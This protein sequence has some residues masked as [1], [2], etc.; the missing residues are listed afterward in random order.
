MFSNFF[1]RFVR[2]G[3]H[4]MVSVTNEGFLGRT[5][6]P[7]Q[8]LAMNVFRAVEN[9]VAIVRAATTGVSAFINPD[10]EIVERVRDSNGND[11]FVS[12][13]LVGDVPLSN[14]K[15]LYT[16][17]GEVFAY[18]VIG[19]AAFIILVSLCAKSW[20]GLGLGN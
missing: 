16:V 11:L 2:E 15:T 5:S 20:S 6:A 9:K 7:Y 14:I 19:V 8:S 17:Y 10:G 18:A 4:F 12:G 1:R 13:V 3:A